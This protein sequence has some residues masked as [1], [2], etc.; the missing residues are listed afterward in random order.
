MFRL[1]QWFLR[2]PGITRTRPTHTTQRRRLS[3]EQL[4]QRWMPSSITTLASFNETNG[5]TPNSLIEDGHGNL[6]GTTGGGGANSAGTVFEVAA[7]SS[8]ISALASFNGANGDTPSSLIED[9]QGN[10]FGITLALPLPNVSP[11]NLGTVFEVAAGTS[12]I[13][14]LTSFSLTSGDIPSS[15]IEDSHGNLFGTTTGNGGANNDGTVFELVGSSSFTTLATFNGSNGNGPV[16]LIVDSHG[17]LFGTTAAGGSNN[18]GTVFELATGS[19]SITTLASFNGADGSGANSLIEDGNGNLFG[20]ATEG[21]ANGDGTMFEVVAGS[22]SITTLASFSGPNGEA[23]TSL[24]EDSHS[25]L[26]GTAEFGGAN[27]DGTVFELTAGSSSISAL[28]SFNGANGKSPGSVI[29]DSYGNLFGTTA[30][31]GAD[32]NGTVFEIPA[33]LPA[34][35]LTASSGSSQ[36]AFANTAFAAPLVVAVTDPAGNP[37]VNAVVTFTGPAGG[38]GVTFPSGTT[39]VTNAQGQASIDV[40]ANGSAGSY[41]VTASVSGAASSASFDLTN[42]PSTVPPPSNAAQSVGVF[43]PSSATWY[44]NGS[45]AAGAPADG[46]V[47]Y[48]GVNW[49]ALSGDFTGDGLSTIVVV[50]PS[51]ETWYISDTDTLGPPSIAP[52]QYGAPGWIPVVGDWNGSGIDGIGVVDPTTGIWYLRNEASAGP[53]DGGT[54]A[55]GAPGW[56]PVAGNWYGRSNGQDGIGMVDPSTETW[57]LRNTPNPGGVNYIPFQYGAPGWTPVVGAWTNSMQTGIGV[58]DGGGMFY[59]RNEVSAG[60]ADAGQFAYGAAG[61]VPLAGNWLNGSATSQDELAPGVGPGAPAISNAM[62]QSTV[63]EALALLRTDGINP[64]LL[65]ELASANYTLAALPPGVLGDTFVQSNTVEI[66]ADG[67]GYGWYVDTSANDPALNPNGTV[68]AGSPASGHEDLLTTVLHEMGH[69]AGRADVAN[70]T[71]G[72]N[73]MDAVLPLGTRRIDAL[74]LVFANGSFV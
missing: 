33:A 68:P 49:Y 55:Y 18:D 36:T 11:D 59:L 53:A 43:D 6:F 24:V 29:E 56:I 74:D 57:Y 9:S 20:V 52:F 13:T 40:S 45:N 38:A 3:L 39:A 44:L 17:N 27:G 65:Q 12:S 2:T 60:K 62:L 5:A 50:D 19:S 35:T 58:Y 32:N 1:A 15:L 70:A 67:A 4:E 25:N 66:S 14:T 34:A 72:S 7:G 21:G 64:T 61:W 16:N 73:L 63:Q 23:P 71:T 41:V 10:L 48:G 69:L 47:E 42:S 28:A 37:I 22:S 8:S 54:F 30:F 26:F 46:E 31:D 51:T